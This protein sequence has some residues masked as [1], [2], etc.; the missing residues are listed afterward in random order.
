MDL[1]A[2]P[3]IIC[4]GDGYFIDCYGPFQ[5]NQNDS[6]IFEYILENDSDLLQ[7]LEPNKTL[8]F[9]DRGNFISSQKCLTIYIKVLF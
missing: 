1:L 3:F 4:C 8:I 6:T 5:V 2:K 7:I 9:L